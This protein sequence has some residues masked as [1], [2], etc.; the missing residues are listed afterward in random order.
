[1]R[2]LA[3]VIFYPWNFVV[4]YQIQIVLDLWQMFFNKCGC[5]IEHLFTPDLT[6]DQG[7]VAKQKAFSVSFSL[8]FIADLFA[9]DRVKH[10]DTVAFNRIFIKIIARI[11][12][13]ING[14]E[15]RRQL[16]R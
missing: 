15:M 10:I 11:F 16:F 9:V 3:L 13:Y 12:A 6:C 1:M 7:G 5:L 4:C 2:V 14:V 8:I